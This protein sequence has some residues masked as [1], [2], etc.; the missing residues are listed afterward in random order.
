MRIAFTIAIASLILALLFCAHVAQD[1][2]KPMAKP[3]MYLLLALTPPMIGNLILVS[4][5]IET[6][7]IIG[8]YVYFLGM[9]LVMLALVRFVGAYC[10]IKWPKGVCV[11]IDALL[12]FDAIQLLANT[13]FGH[14]FS[15]ERIIAYGAPYYRL[16]PYFGQSIHRIIDY[17]I[18]AAML[19]IIFW[20][21]IHVPRIDSERYSVLLA[22]MVFTTI[23]E[24]LYIFSRTPV[25]RSMIGFGVFGLLVFYF[26][27][28]YRPLRLL[29]SM[30]ATVASEM[31]DALY[32][33]DVSGVCIWANKRGME[34]A[35]ITK[36]D[37]DSATERLDT[38]LGGIRTEGETWS[39]THMTGKGDAVQSYVMERRTVTD[40]KGRRIGSFLTVRDNS[41]EQ[42]VLQRE[43]YN[44]THDSLTKVYNRA[45]Y[46][47]LLS[48][49][50]LKTTLLLLIDGDE[51]KSIND[52]YGH[53]VGDRVLQK[54]ARTIQHS[55]RSE[56]MVCRIGGDEFVVLMHYAGPA[57]FGLVRER[58]RHINAL[59]ADTSDGLPPI[60]ISGGV[61]T[62]EQ[63]DSGTELYEHADSALYETKRTGRGGMTVFMESA[64]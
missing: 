16:V 56:D 14:A 41:D 55:F 33:F 49:L 34:L 3:V 6:L 7:S 17:G 13:V 23:W 36:D 46:D 29:D 45:G 30:L 9:D 62:G 2:P 57:Q 43:M 25:D 40:D 61:A 37:F 5:T 64:A 60:S 35:N 39:G 1:S 4:S 12:G 27:L 21:M 47:L 10:S 19:F 51:F 53:E 28:Y 42:K 38:L 8:L 44:A 48:H 31:P 26:S 20:K 58:I 59:L 15:T 18:L 22:T 52:R 24:T 50:D 32:F 63:V 11:F 54:I